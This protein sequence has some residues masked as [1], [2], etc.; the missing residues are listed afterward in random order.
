M[1][2]ETLRN[3][4][5]RYFVLIFLI[6]TIF[7]VILT[8][9][10]NYHFYTSYL[11]YFLNFN[12]SSNTKIF[13]ENY[14]KVLHTLNDINLMATKVDTTDLESLIS[15]VDNNLQSDPTLKVNGLFFI[16]NNPNKLVVSH[17]NNLQLTKTLI[18]TLINKA[19]ISSGIT[20]YGPIKDTTI[21]NDLIIM[22]KP[23]YKKDKLIGFS[24]L[25]LKTNAFKAEAPS[26]PKAFNFM[27]IYTSDKNLIYSNIKNKSLLNFLLKSNL[28]NK[29]KIL[30]NGN[31]YLVRSSNPI[32]N[33]IFYF[34]VPFQF[35]YFVSYLEIGIVLL[36]ILAIFIIIYFSSKSIT[37]SIVKPLEKLK[38]ISSS[39]KSNPS[40]IDP[41]ILNQKTKIVEINSLY[42]AFFSMVSHIKKKNEELESSY[43]ELESVFEDLENAYTDLDEKNKELLQKQEQL[44]DEH[45]N[46]VNAYSELEI[47]NHSLKRSLKELEILSDISLDLVSYKNIKNLIKLALEKLNLIFDVPFVSVLSYDKEEKILVVNTSIKNSNNV[48]DLPS[49]LKVGRGI[50]GYAAMTKSTVVVNNTEKDPR[51][52]GPVSYKSEIAVPIIWENEIL[53]VLDLESDKYSSFNSKRAQDTVKRVANILG[54]AM[55]NSELLKQLKNNFYETI[56][57]LADTIELKDPYTRGHS[58]RVTYYSVKMAKEFGFS[59]EGVEKIRLAAILHD[60]GKIGVRGAVLNKPGRLTEDE[61]KEIEK[62]AVLGAKVL[63]EVAVM[64]DIAVLV[65][66]HHEH[67]NGRGYPDGL[68]GEDIP[69]ESRIISVA[70]AFDAMTSDRPYRKSLG[71]KKAL[72]ILEFEAGNQ[73]DPEII[74]AFLKFFKEGKLNIASNPGFDF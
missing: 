17:T 59:E 54:A 4:F 32:G 23:L 7:F 43:E 48:Q 15:S 27:Y 72:E 65:K 33:I 66:H 73:F 52:L 39:V 20:L 8:V 25:T 14:S 67:W 12:L 56:K 11:D 37:D 31:T 58:E 50:S 44:E 21:G 10:F 45:T 1:K 38:N 6:L 49:K 26:N 34:I 61:R 60:I 24:G 53:G 70:D 41:R 36:S 46:L 57:A 69:L 35:K 19:K 63:N 64:K 22:I 47:T 30:F 55:K 51:F 28:N 42:E 2:A 16:Y 13:V 3:L 71:I 68:K 62:H 40:G 5:V 9:V 18:S 74:E 29:K